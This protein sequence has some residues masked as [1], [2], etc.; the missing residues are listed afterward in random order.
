MHVD[1]LQAAERLQE[2]AAVA[3]RQVAALDQREA[4]VAREVGVLEVGL[5]V[6]PGREQHDA[7]VVAVCRGASA[8]SVSRSVRK[9]GASRWTWQSRN[10]SGSMRDSTMRFSSA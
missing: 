7:R 1:R 3:H 5:V 10:A 2:H 6:R 9:N 8:G 4:E